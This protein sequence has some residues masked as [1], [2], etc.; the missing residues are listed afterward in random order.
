MPRPRPNVVRDGAPTRWLVRRFKCGLALLAASALLACS[1]P[2]SP[3]LPG[4]RD[5]SREVVVLV[6]GITGTELRHPATG[7]VVWGDGRSVFFPRDRGRALA[8]PV[9]AGAPDRPL[10][11]SALVEEVAI[12][13]LI[14]KQAYGPIVRLMAAQGYR[15]G[16]LL[17]PDPE[18]GFFPFP[19]DWRRD[20][21]D[22]AAELASRLEGLR[23]S[24]G[25]DLLEVT[26]ICQS[27]AAHVCRWLVKYGGGSLEAAEA[28]R[29]A[30][31][32][33]LKV[34]KLVLVGTANGGS[35]R[36]LRF[37][38]RGRVYVPLVGRRW[39]PETLFTWP[40]LVQDLPTHRRDLFLD[41]R[42]RTRDVDLFDPANWRRYGWSV[43]GPEGAEL[44]RRD[45]L[46]DWLGGAADRDAFLA[47]ALDRAR[48]F[49]RLLAADAPGFGPIRYY[50][51]QNPY[52]ETPDRA[53][54]VE[55][56]GRWQTWFSGDRRVEEDP[57]L[58]ARMT[59]PGDGHATVAS[60]RHLSPQERAALGSR[61]FQLRGGHFELIL[62]PATQRRLLEILAE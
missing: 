16:S 37:L 34:S 58:A 27:S 13:G 10:E 28:G 50:L 56:G 61:T 43:W 21:L 32:P 22:T 11:A 20:N 59:A 1:L 36:I 55:E 33:T 41:A 25:E 17:D 53:L 45:R 51:I 18:A 57:Y 52:A 39:G 29:A 9:A 42:G 3:T 62:D 46:P 4:A 24:R 38:N 40:S 54:L 23:R 7:R 5:R 31:P 19:Y 14:R 15:P 8:L 2:P 47:R 49:H 12:L 44:A 30:P 6:P 35:L 26:L 48:R 60:Q